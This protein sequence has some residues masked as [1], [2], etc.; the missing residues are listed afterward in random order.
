MQHSRRA[1]GRSSLAKGFGSAS[2]HQLEARLRLDTKG[3]AVVRDF[4]A[5][6]RTQG[7]NLAIS[8][9][10][11]GTEENRLVVLKD[12]GYYCT[13]GPHRRCHQSSPFSRL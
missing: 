5:S 9:A 11:E 7:A 8:K 1:G 2:C 4:R 13:S 12:G 10:A 3:D 6:A